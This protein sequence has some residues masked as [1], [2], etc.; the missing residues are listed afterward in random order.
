MSP[1]QDSYELMFK[2]LWKNKQREAYYFKT[3]ILPILTDLYNER[4][5]Q[6]P[7]WWNII[8]GW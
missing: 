7:W 4:I 5:T 2:F 3:S 8:T 6:Q 1:K